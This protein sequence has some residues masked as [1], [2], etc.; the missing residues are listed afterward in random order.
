MIDLS[1]LINAIAEASFGHRMVQRVNAP[2][3]TCK[4][5]DCGSPVIMNVL[6]RRQHVASI[7]VGNL[8]TVLG[9]GTELTDDQ[10]IALL[11]ELTGRTVTLAPSEERHAA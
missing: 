2:G 1:P 7:A 4:N 5:P 9:P 3:W 8:R 10:V 6:G 11:T